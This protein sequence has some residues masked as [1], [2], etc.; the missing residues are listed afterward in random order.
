M[1][2]KKCALALLILGLAFA[3]LGGAPKAFADVLTDTFQITVTVNFIAIDLKD[4]SGAA[5]TTW[6]LGQVATGSTTTMT[7]DSGGSSEEGIHV[8]NTSNVAVDLASY[9]TNTQSWT[10]AGSAGTDQCVLEAK[11]FAAFQADPPNMTSAVVITSTSS[12]GEDVDTS[13]S[14]GTDR[15]WYYRFTAPSEVTGGGSNTFTVT[16]EASAA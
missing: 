12:P 10:L 7:G 9:A 13:I 14:S 4:Y 8:D 5:Y 15:Y 2:M 11:G 1:K 3:F 16:V 6:A